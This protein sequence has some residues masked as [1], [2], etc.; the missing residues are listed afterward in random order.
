MYLAERR[1]KRPQ[2]FL[3]NQW[4]QPTNEHRR[5]IGV[6]R[7]ELFAVRSYKIPEYGARLCVMLP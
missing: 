4:R 1:K 5:I 7:R 6:C 2:R 3:S